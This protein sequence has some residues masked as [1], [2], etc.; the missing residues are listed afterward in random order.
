M[1]LLLAWELGGGL[2]HVARLQGLG[3]LLRE[4]GHKLTYAFRNPGAA[5]QLRQS[6]LDHVHSAP[7][8]TVMPG[9]RRAAYDYADLLLLRGYESTERLHQ[10]VAGWLDLIRTSGAECIIADHA[11]TACLAAHVAGIRSITVGTGFTVPPLTKP[12]N[13]LMPNSPE[14]EAGQFSLENRLDRAVA[15]L[16]KQYG[17]P[18][19]DRAVEAVG[20]AGL[21]LL[22]CVSDYP[23]NPVDANLRAMETM[24]RAFGKPVGFSDHTLGTEVALAAVALGA[25]VI[26]K[27]FTLDRGLP[28][29][30]HAAS[31]QPDELFVLISGIRVVESALGTGIKRPAHSELKTL[32][33]VRKSLVA[34]RP[35]KAG[36]RIS[37]DM[38]AVRRPGGGLAPDKRVALI[39]RRLAHDVEA[40]GLVTLEDT[41]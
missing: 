6:D 25:I 8:M 36:D 14:P 21:V 2:G 7:A 22:H 28:G 17:K 13:P 11:P 35:L 33:C 32:D 27:H 38:L 10:K 39:G 5:A 19:V 24:R 1:N 3:R 34:A 40:G 37:E 16:L 41:S 20:D 29:P 23:A 18:E 30:D 4:D 15:D 12:L 9:S 26:E 31:L